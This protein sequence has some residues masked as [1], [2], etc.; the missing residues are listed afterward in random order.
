MEVN[1]ACQG[2][3]VNDCFIHDALPLDHVSVAVQFDV[4]HDA[5]A[6]GEAARKDLFQCRIHFLDLEAGE[7]AEAAHVDGENGNAERGGEAG[8]GGVG[9]GAGAAPAGVGGGGGGL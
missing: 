2:A 1:H 7:E 3:F 5:L 8:G 9:C 6:A 4:K